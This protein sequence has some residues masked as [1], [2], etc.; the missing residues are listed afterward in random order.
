[1]DDNRITKK[2]F[3]WSRYIA[4]PNNNNWVWKTKTLLDSIRDFGGLLN[5]D[6]IWNEL[7]KIVGEDT[8]LMILLDSDTGGRFRF[9]CDI[10]SSHMTEQYVR[11]SSALNRKIFITQIRCGCL[12]LEVEL[13]RYRSPKTPLKER[14]CALCNGEIGDEVH[15]ITACSSLEDP[16]TALFS[17]YTSMDPI[18]QTKR[19]LIACATDKSVSKSAYQYRAN[20]LR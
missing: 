1:M 8:I 13:D 7:A 5:I 12:P 20:L 19:V 3:L 18:E 11:S 17:Y 16:M 10:K 15:F 2:V 14:L 4:G 9:Y 6:E